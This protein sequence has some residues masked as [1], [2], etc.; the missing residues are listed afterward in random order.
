[1]WPTSTKSYPKQF[2]PIVKGKSFLRHTYE[3][4]AKVYKPEDILVSTEIRYKEFIEN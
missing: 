1:M 3:R 2:R 4:F